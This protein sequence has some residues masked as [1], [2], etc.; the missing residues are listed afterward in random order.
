ML[1]G[2]KLVPQIL[3]KSLISVSPEVTET[4]LQH[5]VDPPKRLMSQ[6]VTTE[7]RGTV[8]GLEVTI[9]TGTES[10]FVKF[11]IDSE[12]RRYYDSNR[13]ALNKPRL[14]LLKKAAKEF[15]EKWD[16]AIR[17]SEGIDDFNQY[18]DSVGL[19]TCRGALGFHVSA[20]VGKGL[21]P[22]VYEDEGSL[23]FA[24]PPNTKRFQIVGS[25]TDMKKSMF[26]GKYD[27]VVSQEKKS[28]SKPEPITV[29]DDDA[30]DAPMDDQKADG[31]AMQ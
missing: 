5:F 10:R 1:A 22:C 6:L 13:E 8:D 26:P 24:V 17:N 25:F 2:G 9:A 4:V 30:K 28:K 15:F 27:V 21:Y 11:K 12:L 18:R 7:F 31:P 16:V 23:Y 20:Q 3:D 14:K 19:N 29:E